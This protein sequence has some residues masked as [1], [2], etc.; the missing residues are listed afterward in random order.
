MKKKGKEN[1]V[2]AQKG[3]KNAKKHDISPKLV[4]GMA[5]IGSSMT[6][7]AKVYGC[8]EELLNKSYRDPYDKGRAEASRDILAAM[9]KKGVNEGDTKMLIHLSKQYCGHSDKI[10]QEHDVSMNPIEEQVYKG[11][12]NVGAC[13]LEGRKN[14]GL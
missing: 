10:T 14:D 12:L 9:F 7:I 8:S 11:M 1:S 5:N 4:Q 3:N 2:G 6:D 13:I